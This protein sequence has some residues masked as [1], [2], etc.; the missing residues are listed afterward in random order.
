MT[1]LRTMHRTPFYTALAA[2]L[3]L[4]LSPAADP[5]PNPQFNIHGDRMSFIDNGEIKVGVD[6]DLGGAITW[7]STP[8]HDNLINNND[9]GR[10][11]QLSFYSGPRPFEPDG[12]QT[13]KGWK[14]WAWNP[15]QSGDVFGHRAKVVELTNTG[16][17][18]HLA[19]IPMQWALD[20]VPG[21]CRFEADLKL[22][23]PMLRVRYSLINQRADH[24]WYGAHN[25]ELPAVY[26]VSALDHLMAYTGEQPFTGGSLTR[27]FKP[28]DQVFPWAR[29]IATEGWVAAVGDDDWGLGVC[30]PSVYNYLGGTS[31]PAKTWNSDDSPTM[32]ISPVSTDALDHNIVFDF[33]VMIRAGKLTELRDYFTGIMRPRTPPV[34]KFTSDRQHWVPRG[35]T[36]AGWPIKDGLK[37]TIAKGKT[38]VVD[39]PVQ[40]YPAAAAPKLRLTGTWT[41]FTGT[42][43]IT[44]KKQG[45][46]QAT[47]ANSATFPVPESGKES[48]IEIDLST[49][50]GYD[51]LITQLTLWP[52]DQPNAEGQVIVKAIELIGGGTKER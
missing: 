25:Q 32:Y 29:F 31:S 28:K 13:H 49:A 12:K 52:T 42:G 33:E 35:C 10:Q 15:I 14:N 16:T 51:G 3:S 50:P 21:D 1:S 45:G 36:D 41:G 48:S 23:G 38:A 47:K 44:W 18:V 5:K 6:Q 40:P 8:G 27:I 39:G 2:M 20:D 22:E 26:T 34:W 43:H 30:N 17:A 11:I 37:L 19:S 46:D 24:A 4:T 9:W 7:I